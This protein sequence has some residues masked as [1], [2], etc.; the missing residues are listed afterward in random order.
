MVFG[1]P[2]PVVTE[3]LDVTRKGDGVPDRL[4]APPPSPH[5]RPVQHGNR[6]IHAQANAARTAQIPAPTSV[7]A[8]L[9]DSDSLRV[10]LT[11]RASRGGE[12]AQTWI[13]SDFP[14]RPAA[15]RE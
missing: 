10:P 4:R 15:V 6:N 14:H 9:I 1:N 8:T 11:N 13:P 12:P 7:R 3:R 5:G 2:K